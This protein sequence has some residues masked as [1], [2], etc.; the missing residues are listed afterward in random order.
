VEFRVLGDLEVWHDGEALPLGAHQQ[1]AVL[2]I[3]V[4]HV[5]EVV[6][7]DRL[8]DELWGDEPPAQ[9]AKTVQVHISR[10][11]KTLADGPIVETTHAG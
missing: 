11:R 10:L 7:S 3:L 2:A 1:R 8:I 5:R 9:A 4:L 6:T